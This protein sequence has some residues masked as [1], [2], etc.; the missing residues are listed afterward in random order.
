VKAASTAGA[1]PKRSFVGWRMHPGALL[2]G[3]L[4]TLALP[5]LD[6]WPL[7]WVGLVPLLLALEGRRPAGA[8]RLGFAAGLLHAATTIYWVTY[9]MKVYGGMPWPAGAAVMLLLAAY[10]AA[11]PAAWAAGVAFV[12]AGRAPL[13]PGALLLALPLWIGLE[14]VRTWLLSGFPWMLLGYSQWRQLEVIQVADLGGVYAVSGLIAAANLGLYALLRA[15]RL[16][17]RPAAAL[18]AGAGLVVVAALAY[19]SLVLGRD[20]SRSG[21]PR[22]DVAVVQGNIEQ[23]Q[24]WD[25]AYQQATLEIYRSLTLEVAAQGA[26]VVVWPETAVPAFF[27]RD[28]QV[29]PAV[30]D[31]ARRARVDLIFGAPSAENRPPRTPGGEPRVVLFNSAYVVSAE[32]AVKGRYD[33]QHLVPFGEYVPLSGALFFVNR[34]AQGIGDFEPGRGMPEV[35]AGGARVGILIC[36]E[37]IFPGLARRVAAG[38]SVLVNITNDA[39]FG[40]TAAPWQHLAQAVFR[41]VE[42]K[43]PLVRAANTGVSA[44]VDPSGRVDA[45]LGLFTPGTLAARIALPRAGGTTLYARVGDRFAQLCALA[46]AAALVAVGRARR[47]RPLDAS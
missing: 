27:Q 14:W 31:V 10:M 36:Y 17:W 38:A 40:R 44:I 35:S 25:P 46:A 45:A 29:R 6:L 7:A 5:D 32:G 19:G 37:A 20:A 28:P 3:L 42:L 23:A 30:L 24:K 2:S 11:F 43:R 13:P 1:P 16:G 15:P 18:G 8:A 22:L 12:A 33:K 39:W 9:T 41:A 4:L 34:L 47:R 26:Q 21:G